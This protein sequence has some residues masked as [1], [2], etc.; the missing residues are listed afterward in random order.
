MGRKIEHMDSLLCDVAR[1]LPKLESTRTEVGLIEVVLC[2]GEEQVA[3]FC[4]ST[5]L[6]YLANDIYYDDVANW[7]DCDRAL[8]RTL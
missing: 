5:A 3:A 2:R 6:E 1:A 4:L 8:V 7:S